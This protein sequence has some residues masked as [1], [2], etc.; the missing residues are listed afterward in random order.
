MCLHLLYQ[1][2]H[3][4]EQGGFFVAWLGGFSVIRFQEKARPASGKSTRSCR[5]RGELW[6]CKGTIVPLK[7]L[8]YGAYRV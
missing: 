1:A 5:P 8:E 3:A 7:S 2:K 4:A 6:S